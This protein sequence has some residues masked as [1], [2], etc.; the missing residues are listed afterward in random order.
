[1]A[2]R[3]YSAAVNT[4]QFDP[5][6]SSGSD[7]YD[8]SD[9]DAQTERRGFLVSNTAK[10]PVLELARS[11]LCCGLLPWS[12]ALLWLVTIMCS[13]MVIV[14]LARG[15]LAMYHFTYWGL[16]LVA[17]FGASWLAAIWVDHRTDAG[18]GVMGSR[19]GRLERL[20]LATMAVPVI[21]VQGLVILLI[22]VIPMFDAN[23]LI[24]LSGDMQLGLANFGNIVVHY[25]PFVA[26]VVSLVG[27]APAWSMGVRDMIGA[28]PDD[29]P[30]K[31]RG[32]V[33]KQYMFVQ[34]IAFPACFSG[35][36]SAMFDYNSSYEVEVPH[37]YILSIGYAY[38]VCF[39]LFMWFTFGVPFL[40][41]I[42]AK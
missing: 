12:M 3:G 31:V 41:S 17:L 32:T 25:L 19:S 10:P 23:I 5:R 2:H 18:S 24:A 22:T 39:F 35:L 9:E 15:E 34:C 30:T 4:P 29:G 6:E 33:F 36:Y 13:G 21:A 26:L 27:R 8:E 42:A 38:I 28:I 7:S 20:T 40:G 14:Q 1:M 16:I 11:S 37:V